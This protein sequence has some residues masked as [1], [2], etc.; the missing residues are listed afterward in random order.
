MSQEI[1]ANH[2]QL[3]AEVMDQCG[4]TNNEEAVHRLGVN[5]EAIGGLVEQ[6]AEKS[7]VDVAE[8]ELPPEVAVI[9]AAVTAF[10]FGALSER[11]R[12]DRGGETI[13]PSYFVARSIAL[14]GGAT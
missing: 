6:I 3:A 1:D 8:S 14:P 12:I 7:I 10:V 2:I 5:Y 4:T 11:V 13:P 9:S